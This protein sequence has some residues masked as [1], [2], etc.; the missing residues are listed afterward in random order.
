MAGHSPQPASVRSRGTAEN[1]SA[2]REFHF[3]YEMTQF[4]DFRLYPNKNGLHIASFRV[5]LRNSLCLT[6]QDGR[7]RRSPKVTGRPRPPLA[8]GLVH[9]KPTCRCAARKLVF[10]AA[11]VQ[12]IIKVKVLAS[13]LKYEEDFMIRHL[14]LQFIYPLP[15]VHGFA[16]VN[17]KRITSSCV[18]TTPAFDQNPDR[19]PVS[20]PEA[21]PTLDATPPHGRSQTSPPADFGHALHSNFTPTLDLEPGPGLNFDSDLQPAYDFDSVTGHGSREQIVLGGSTSGVEAI[22][23]EL[24]ASSPSGVRDLFRRRDTRRA[25]RTRQLNCYAFD[26]LLNGTIRILGSLRSR[27]ASRRHRHR[28]DLVKSKTRSRRPRTSGGAFM[29]YERVTELY[30]RLMSARVRLGEDLI[31]GEECD[32]MQILLFTAAHTRRRL[33]A[34]R[35]KPLMKFLAA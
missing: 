16:H 1:N 30:R 2:C 24:R 33:R 23:H 35:T 26:K 3:D 11:H 4:G 10:Y 8:L 15:F 25:R 34:R 18:S 27:R 13:D 29:I 21:Y 19:S 6:G 9:R 20:R 32:F 17:L 31:R 28:D 14:K 5:E 22:K 7:A 12:K